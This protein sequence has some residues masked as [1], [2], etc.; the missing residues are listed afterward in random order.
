M[1]KDRTTKTAFN[2]IET[3]S[4][5]DS[6]YDP[7]SWHDGNEITFTGLLVIGKLNPK[8]PGI[9]PTFIFRWDEKAN[10]VDIDIENLKAADVKEFLGHHIDKISSTPRV[11]KA[12]VVWNC[13]LI[14]QGQITFN[15]GFERT[16]L[17]KI[18]VNAKGHKMP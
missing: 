8:N 9:L 6:E 4:F 12:K 11:F 3:K 15:L 18:R 7:I 14:Y 13:R 17:E 5:L 16:N 1:N 2:I 10:T